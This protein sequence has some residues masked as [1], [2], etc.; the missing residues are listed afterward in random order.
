M[1]AAPDNG[2]NEKA[3]QLCSTLDA[4]GHNNRSG[5]SLT[6]QGILGY[7]GSDGVS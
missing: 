7:V 4:L 3:G 6:Q 1:S 2:F 5:S